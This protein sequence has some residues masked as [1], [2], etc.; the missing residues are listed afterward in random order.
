[1][2][3]DS[4]NVIMSGL[5]G[6]QKAAESAPKN[7]PHKKVKTTETVSSSIKFSTTSGQI[8]TLGEGDVGQL[9]L[10]PDILDRTKPAKVNLDPHFTIV[11]AGGMRTVGVT[12]NG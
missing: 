11:R 4:H 9:G 5:R 3:T 2:K 1:M 10:G 12:E 6:K 7:A 8:L